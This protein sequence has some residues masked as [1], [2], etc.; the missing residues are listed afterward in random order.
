[1]RLTLGDAPAVC[2]RKTVAQRRAATM[3]R[4]GALALL[5]FLSA[6]AGVVARP[7]GEARQQSLQERGYAEGRNLV[8][9]F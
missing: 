3:V 2:C 5:V 7:V 1:M 8:W 4:M 9:E 6:L